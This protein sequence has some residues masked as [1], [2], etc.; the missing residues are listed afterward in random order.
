MKV[1]N[2][3]WSVK[4]IEQMQQKINPKP[5]YQRGQVWKLQSRQLLIDSIL[6]H[7][8]I[9]KIYLHDMRGVGQYDYDVTDGQQRLRA[10]WSFL[11]DEFRL[12]DTSYQTNASWRGSLFSELTAKHQKEIRQFKLIVAFDLRCLPTMRFEKSSPA[13]NAVP[14]SPLRSWG[15]AFRLNSET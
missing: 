11:A 12:S 6:C 3:A 1:R 13:C 14:G 4:R 8:D 9:P 7:F 5:Q 10:I 15:T 2:D